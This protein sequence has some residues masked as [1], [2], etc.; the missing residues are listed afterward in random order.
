VSV[1]WLPAGDWLIAAEPAQLLP[2]RSQMAFTLMFHII[3][4]PMGVAL[5]G[6]M[7]IANYKGLKRNDPVALTLARRWS[8]AG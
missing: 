7:L 6:I 4:V 1:V 3:L 8:H 2:A 5:P